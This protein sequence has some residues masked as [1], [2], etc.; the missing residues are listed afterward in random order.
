[1]TTNSTD[2]PLGPAGVAFLESR[3]IDIEIATRHGVHTCRADSENKTMVP[4]IRGTVLAFPFF[5]HGVVVNTKY[6]AT[7]SKKFWQSPG[8]TAPFY[9]ADIMDDPALANDTPLTIVEG[10]LDKLA[11]ETA[12]NPFVVSVPE[13]APPPSPDHHIRETPS[14]SDAAGKFKFMWNNRERLQRSSASCSLSTT[15]RRASGWPTS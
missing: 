15:T 9:G 2:L 13:G 1:M 7:K 10:E 4:D 14:G 12:G 3:G 8:G 11:L 5:D 6:R